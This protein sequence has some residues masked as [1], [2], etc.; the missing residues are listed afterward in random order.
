M[1]YDVIRK[2]NAAAHI[3]LLFISSLSMSIW[4]CFCE[5]PITCSIA[6]GVLTVSGMLIKRCLIKVG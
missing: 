6:L 2:V 3:T 1:R 4:G 5:Y